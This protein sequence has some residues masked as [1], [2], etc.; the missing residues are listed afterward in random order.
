MADLAWTANT[1][2]LS[3]GP[4]AVGIAAETIAEGDWLYSATAT[5]VGVAT[6]ADAAKDTVI[7]MALN[8]GVSGK[9]I[10]S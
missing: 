9:H 6:N 10:G 4:T 8:G 7:G 3:S 5:T 1:V 2:I